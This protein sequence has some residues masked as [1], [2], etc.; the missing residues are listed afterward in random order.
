MALYLTRYLNVPPTVE[1]VRE[2]RKLLQV[3]CRDHKAARLTLKY[4]HFLD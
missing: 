4:S 1:G 3:L 2:F